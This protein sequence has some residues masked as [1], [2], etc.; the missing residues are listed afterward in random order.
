LK[1]QKFTSGSG[2]IE[3]FNNTLRERVS[4]L[5]R[6]VLSCSKKVANPIGVIT[7]CICHDNSTRAA[8]NEHD[9]DI[10]TGGT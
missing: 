10:M 3:R 2:F 8:A 9:M 7:L 5:V 6:E 4:R 1:E